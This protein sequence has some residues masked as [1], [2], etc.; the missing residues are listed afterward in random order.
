MA[1]RQLIGT[2]SGGGSKRVQS[3]EGDAILDALENEPGKVHVILTKNSGI[4]YREDPTKF[5]RAYTDDGVDS[6]FN[7]LFVQTILDTHGSVALI[8]AHEMGHSLALTSRNPDRGKHD[9]GPFPPGH[10][11]LMKSGSPDPVTGVLPRNP[12]RWLPHEDW[13]T[14]NEKAPD[15][16]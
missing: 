11:G 14:A 3:A 13:K 1:M 16:E 10:P 8:E 6:S 7:M 9:P 12:G 15:Y 4:P 2:L 5:I